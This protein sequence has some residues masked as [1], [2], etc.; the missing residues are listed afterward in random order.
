MD[1][2][3]NLTCTPGR[4]EVRRRLNLPSYE[5]LTPRFESMVWKSVTKFS[6]RAS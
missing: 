5:Q 2:R 6:C 3:G 4:P 1:V